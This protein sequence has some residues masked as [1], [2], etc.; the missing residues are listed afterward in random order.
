MAYLLPK[1]VVRCFGVS[2]VENL[3]IDKPMQIG[4]NEPLLCDFS[5]NSYIIL[6]FGKEIV[7]SVR[8]ITRQV[9]GN[10]RIRLRFGES[11]GETCS[12][13]GFKNSTN[14]HATRDMVVNL[15][16]YSDMCFG[17]TAFRFLRIDFIDNT[18]AL[19]KSIVANLEINNEKVIGKFH[20]DD[21]L[22]NKIFDTAAYTVRL[23]LQN[24]MIWD[25][26]KRDRLV[27]IGDMYPEV[28]A[29]DSLYKKVDNIE[30]SLD[31]IK[32]QTELPKWM[33]R[34]P[35]YSM[36]WILILKEHYNG[37]GN[38][39][40][41][42]KQKEYLVGLV[43]QLKQCISDDGHIDF[44]IIKG[45]ENAGYFIDWPSHPQEESDEIKTNDE[46]AGVQA[47]AVLAFKAAKELYSI[48]G[49]DNSFIDGV[50][51]KITEKKYSVIK[52]KQIASLRIL[53]GIGDEN[54]KKIV[55]E[56]GAKG[57]S[58]F[59]SYFILKAVSS[60][61]EYEKSL[62]MMKEYYG[63]MLDLGA[64]TFW[65]D[66]DMEWLSDN[67]C[68]IT[69]LATRSQKDIHGDFGAFCYKGYRHSLCHGWS[70]GVIPYLMHVVAGIEIKS[71]G[72]KEIAIN[73]HLS[74]LKH[75]KV[76]YPT[77]YG[78]LTVEHRV[79]EN[80]KVNTMVNAPSQIKIIK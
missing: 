37:K 45:V 12:E 73:P 50:I 11:V 24:G 77:P 4:F 49:I 76:T 35:T 70:S 48:L 10:N 16:T 72:C 21:K 75:L 43:E 55:T 26:V 61:G 5:A 57:L 39:T 58:T 17:Q 15:Q 19:I 56:N 25:G 78:K 67:V 41:L 52:M 44:S 62:S 3:F 46:A 80:G 66:F 40:Y 38:L 6:D 33:N 2:G 71:P 60:F 22:V 68:G 8:I 74:G 36:W 79:D 54:D 28:F 65:E 30:N 23:C 27:W 14:D 64:T 29:L 69:K 63:A 9:E 34:Y 32:D 31:F 59:M 20:S 7:G 1:K 47:L 53:A 13:I 42:E 51:R 18:S